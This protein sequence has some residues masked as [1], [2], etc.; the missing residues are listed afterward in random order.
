MQDTHCQYQYDVWLK[1]RFLLLDPKNASVIHICSFYPCI[2]SILNVAVWTCKSNFSKHCCQNRISPPKVFSREQRP[3]K[4]DL[5][6]FSRYWSCHASLSIKPNVVHGTVILSP[7]PWKGWLLV[8][9]DAVISLSSK[10]AAGASYL[11]AQPRERDGP[12]KH[13]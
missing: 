10:P 11:P 1:M 7:I 8:R 12:F 2:H 9:A 6:R 4:I 3:S 5:Y 13:S